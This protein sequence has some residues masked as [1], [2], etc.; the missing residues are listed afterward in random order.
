MLRTVSNYTPAQEGARGGASRLNIDT[1]SR[2]SG[3]KEDIDRLSCQRPI[4]Q[5]T[6]DRQFTKA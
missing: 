1:F 4:H 3:V 2:K 6:R 5:N